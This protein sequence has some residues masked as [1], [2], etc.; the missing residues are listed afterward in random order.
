MMEVG[1]RSY[2]SVAPR[3]KM[4]AMVDKLLSQGD[5]VILMIPIRKGV[6]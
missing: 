4:I 2:I 1:G 6:P 5:D 3:I